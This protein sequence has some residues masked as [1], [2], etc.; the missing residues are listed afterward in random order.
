M[1]LAVKIPRI[2]VKAKP[3]ALYAPISYWETS[4]EEVDKVTGGCG[5]GG[6][7]DFLVPDRIWGLSIFIA[8]RIHDWM[9]HVGKTLQDKEQADRIFLNN[10]VRIIQGN[11]SKFKFLNRW[12]LKG[13]KNYFWAVSMFGGPAFWNSKNSETEFKNI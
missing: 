8:C 1:Q 10:M 12:R 5:P 7:G 3:V 2:H 9:Y 11:P 13:A 6:F 4:I